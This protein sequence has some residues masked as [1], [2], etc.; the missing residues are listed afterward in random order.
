MRGSDEVD[1]NFLLS[2]INPEY[3]EDGSSM[4]QIEEAIMDHLQ[5]FLFKI[6][7][8]LGFPE[9]ISFDHSEGEDN[10]SKQFKGDDIFEASDLFPAGIMGWLTGQKH[11]ALNCELISRTVRFDHDCTKRHYKI[12]FHQV[13]ACSKVL[14]LPVLHM[15]TAKEFEEVFLMAFSKCQFFGKA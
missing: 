2:V 3:S 6:E 15:K 13:G 7:N 1:A 12:C 11:K 9:A 10:I 4:K 14:T 8:L 5:D